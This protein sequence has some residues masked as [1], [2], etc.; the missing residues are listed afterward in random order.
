[1]P[2][3]I[4][5]HGITHSE[6]AVLLTAG[7]Y[8]PLPRDRF[9]PHA[10]W[11]VNN[12]TVREAGHQVQL[13]DALGEAIN[14][15]REWGPCHWIGLTNE[16]IVERIDAENEIIGISNMFSHNWPMIRKLVMLLQERFPNIPLILGGEH[17]TSLPEAILRES[18]VNVCALGEGEETM[19]D[20]LD[21]HGGKK[22]LAEVEGI[23]FLDD[24]DKFVE[25]PS[26]RRICNV[27]DI[28]MP[29][30]NLFNIK[31]YVDSSYV[32]GMQYKDAP[33][34]NRVLLTAGGHID[35]RRL[36]L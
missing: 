13:I 28:P 15:M 18:A 35:R 34:S 5:D 24:E 26:R 21:A 4:N 23:A 3:V 2:W 30:W 29:A 11:E 20:L 9:I 14:Q 31:A 25:T 17:A 1:M 22:P 19:L 6:W 27:D 32:H 16:E 7:Y 8:V 36:E 33:P 12:E 10:V